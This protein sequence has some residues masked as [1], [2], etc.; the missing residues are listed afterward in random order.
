MTIWDP[1]SPFSKVLQDLETWFRSLPEHLLIRQTGTSQGTDHDRPGAV[2]MLHFLYHSIACDLTRI[3]LPGY[4]FPLAKAFQNAP[5]KFRDQC[6]SQCRSHADEVAMLA[7]I[8]LS[9]DTRAF[10]DLHSLMAIFE[11][12]KIQIIHAA[13]AT[14]NSRDA[15]QMASENIRA[16][17]NVLDAMHSLQGK[18]NLFVR[19]CC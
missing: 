18:T 2:F 14:S 6:R 8:G 1:K 12:T 3:S 11:S 4:D 19:C 9:E 15:R 10:D 16:N 17:L 13:T 7:H 5:P